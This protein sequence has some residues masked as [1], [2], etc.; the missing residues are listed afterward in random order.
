MI[1]EH[2]LSELSHTFLSNPTLAISDTFETCYLQTLT[3]LEHF[4]VGRSL[5]KRIVCTCIEPSETTAESLYFEFAIVEEA[6][7]D[8]S[9]FILSPRADG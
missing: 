4:N 3:L 5:R 8:S 2:W 7:V 6:L 9:D 1:L